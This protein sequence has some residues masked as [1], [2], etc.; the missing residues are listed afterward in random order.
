M[1]DNFWYQVPD[2]ERY[3]LTEFG[4]WSG[5]G[6]I[7]FNSDIEFDKYD[8]TDWTLVTAYF[9][10]TKCSDASREIIA[11]DSNYYFEHAVSTLCLQYN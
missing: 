1:R 3:D 6:I 2:S 4:H 10:L 11:R 8:N 7:S 5:T 9:N